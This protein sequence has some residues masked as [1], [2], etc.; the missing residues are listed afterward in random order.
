MPPSLEK[1]DGPPVQKS[2]TSS[3]QYTLSSFPTRLECHEVSM[4]LSTAKPHCVDLP[5]TLLYAAPRHVPLRVVSPGRKLVTFAAEI[6]PS[7]ALN[8]PFA[9]NF[10]AL[11]QAR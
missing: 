11:E 5:P 9:G 2:A 7:A 3:D 10:V 6:L 1:S 4:N 8:D